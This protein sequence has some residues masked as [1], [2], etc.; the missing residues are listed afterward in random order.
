MANGAYLEALGAGEGDVLYRGTFNA[1][2]RA[3]L[4]R[5]TAPAAVQASETG[6]TEVTLS[7]TPVPN[8]TAYMISRAVGGSGWQMVCDVCPSGE[9]FVDTDAIPGVEHTYNV[10]AIFPL[11]IS[12][13]TQSKT[14][15]VGAAQLAAAEASASP[16]VWDK[17]M[18][19]GTPVSVTDA[20]D[21]NVGAS[22]G[23]PLPS[24]PTGTTT[25]GTGTTTPPTGSNPDPCLPVM[26]GKKGSFAIY[27]KPMSTGTPVPGTEADNS[28]V[29]GS[30]GTPITG[31]GGC[32]TGGTGT[33]TGTGT[34]TTG[35]MPSGN[36]GAWGTQTNQFTPGGT[37]AG[38]MP[39]TGTATQPIVHTATPITASTQTN[40]YL[41]I[42]G[43]IADGLA[44][45]V[46]QAASTLGLPV[47][48]SAAPIAST[49]TQPMNNPYL[50]I[51]GNLTDTL[52]QQ[53]TQLASTVGLPLIHGATPITTANSQTTNGQGV[54]TGIAGAFAAGGLQPTT[55][56][57]AMPG[58]AT[59]VSNDPIRG[60]LTGVA[61]T[62]GN[63]TNPLSPPTGAAANVTGP[64]TVSVKW[65]ASSATGVTGYRVNRRVNGGA[66][67]VLNTVGSG[68]LTYSDAFFPVTMF[69]SGPARVSYSVVALKSSA[70]SSASITGDVVVQPAVRTTGTTTCRLDYQRADNMWA[71][72]GRPDG[73]LG[74]ETISLAPAQDKVFITDWKYEKTRN[75]GSNYYGSHLRIATNAGPGTIRLHLRSATVT[76]LAVFLRTGSDT[77]WIRMDPGSTKQLQADLMEVFCGN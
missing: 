59:P 34:V 4:A 14:L 39:V 53:V 22:G 1:V 18:S 23:T 6:E 5:P 8:A 17:P 47:V 68:T 70:V 60:M 24:T 46:T 27:T 45:R 3:P 26:P 44:Q 55:I 48:H 65:Q 7:W 66:W 54:F 37:P 64:G 43:N 36:P 11:G 69:A 75:D 40:P 50:S 10:A 31:S 56:A 67:D 16:V 35:G 49:N 57:A 77:F 73:P 76:G 13:R 12:N 9:E 21:S 15:T 28:N 62:L 29:G 32:P 41:V 74:T 30:A 33:G 25:P 42:M 61:S 38:S 19:T 51:V 72:F 20:N 52:A 58:T 2:A 71:A 63:L